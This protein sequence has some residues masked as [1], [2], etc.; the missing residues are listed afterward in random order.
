MMKSY[1]VGDLRR[2][3]KES[4]EFKPVLGPNVES[5]NKRNNEKSYKDSEKRAKDYDGGLKDPKKGTLPPKTDGN[6]TTLDYNPVTEPDKAY[7]ERVEA[8]A[9]GYTS[10]LE[11]DNGIEKAAEFDD[12]GKIFKQ[13]KDAQTKRNELKDKIETSGLQGH[14]LPH[15]KK[16]TLD[17]SSKPK[18]KRLTFKNTTF[19]NEQQMLDR[20]PEHY[21]KDGQ[22]IYMCDKSKNEYIVECVKSQKTGVMETNIIGYKNEAKAKDQVDR[23][24]E[25]MEYKT[26][27]VSGNKINL[28]E[29]ANGD[30][31]LHNMFD[32]LRKK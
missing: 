23:I 32:I 2:I 29:R 5:E 24:F 14:N 8:Q 17:E 10:K 25:L 12:E 15:E 30:K 7:K 31:N 19:L 13:F 21:K 16:H 26:S 9:K 3:I 4:N 22:K 20:I 6:K 28:N 27:K 11:Q 18:A 1:K